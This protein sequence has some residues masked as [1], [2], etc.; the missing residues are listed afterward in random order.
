MNTQLTIRNLPEPINYYLRKKAKLTN[1]SLNQTIIDELSEKVPD[2]NK[3]FSSSLSW[4]IGSGLDDY[5]LEAL[6]SE[7][8]LQ[9]E[10][11]ARENDL[12]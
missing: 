8:R 9:K 12:L 7:D 4:F 6:H 10:K 2:L 1:K 11:A 3:P 5:T